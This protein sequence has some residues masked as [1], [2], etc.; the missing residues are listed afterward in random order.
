[1]TGPLCLKFSA[2]TLSCL[3]SAL[4]QDEL[5]VAMG[6]GMAEVAGEMPALR[7]HGPSLEQHV[8]GLTAGADR[9]VFGYNLF[10]TIFLVVTIPVAFFT[11]VDLPDVQ[12]L[13]DT[14][15][16]WMS[17]HWVMRV[18]VNISWADFTLV[19]CAL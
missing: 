9:S 8:A 14:V 15:E 3:G 6:T 18:G 16:M 19:T 2:P 11:L 17:V 4:A 7:T 5:A 13:S 12:N 1:M 10:E